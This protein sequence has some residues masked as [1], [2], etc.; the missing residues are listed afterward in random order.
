MHPY[1]SN[2]VAQRLAVAKPRE[3]E[4]GL[5]RPAGRCTRRRR[6]GN[7]RD[8]AEAHPFPSRP[9]PERG[10]GRKAG[11]G[12]RLKERV[13]HNDGEMVDDL[14]KASF[15]REEIQAIKVALTGWS[16]VRGSDQLRIRGAAI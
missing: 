9:T 1:D 2:V 16:P 14:I 10:R 8:G 6:G 4:R 3:R 7:R 11:P 12:L 5:E 13:E 15:S